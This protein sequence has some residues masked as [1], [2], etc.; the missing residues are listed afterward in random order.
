M[1]RHCSLLKPHTERNP[2]TEVKSSILPRGFGRERNPNLTFHSPSSLGALEFCV[3]F[4][5]SRLKL[6]LAYPS[7]ALWYLQ[8]PFTLSSYD[9]NNL[10]KVWNFQKA[11]LGSVEGRLVIG[12]ANGK[13][14]RVKAAVRSHVLLSSINGTM[15]RSSSSYTS[16]ARSR[17]FCLY[18]IEAPLVTSWTEENPGRRF[19]GCGL[20]KGEER[21][22]HLKDKA[23]SKDKAS[24]A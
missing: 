6:T 16:E 14:V 7:R 13:R 23:H 21:L 9:V 3:S 11:L 22:A 15:E 1:N 18:N 4:P 2:S 24:I 10:E 8:L 17:V 19:Y 20:Y 12:D 5:L